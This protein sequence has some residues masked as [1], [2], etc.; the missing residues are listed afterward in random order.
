MSAKGKNN[1]TSRRAAT[2][3]IEPFALLELGRH[4]ERLGRI[5]NEHY[6]RR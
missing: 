4:R 1:S 3:A 5:D 6:E 2:I